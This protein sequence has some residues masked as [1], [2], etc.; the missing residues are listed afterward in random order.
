MAVNLKVAQTVIKMVK[1]FP[2]NF[3]VMVRQRIKFLNVKLADAVELHFKALAYSQALFVKYDFQDHLNKRRIQDPNFNLPSQ[4]NLL[5]A[6]SIF[7]SLRPRLEQPH[8]QI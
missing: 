4:H 7:Q 3:G 2:L 5:L 6:S 1:E 8:L